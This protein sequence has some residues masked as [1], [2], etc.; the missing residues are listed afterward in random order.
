MADIT[1]LDGGPGGLG[2]H[3]LSSPARLD[4]CRLCMAPPE[5]SCFTQTTISNNFLIKKTVNCLEQLQNHDATIENFWTQK[6]EH[7]TR[8]GNSLNSMQ[9]R[10]ETPAPTTPFQH[11]YAGKAKYIEGIKGESCTLQLPKTT[12]VRLH[13]KVAP[14][15]LIKFCRSV[16]LVQMTFDS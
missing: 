3:G 13:R 16:E 6:Q 10:D 9:I 4:M 11:T 15:C 12:F 14:T 5:M 2:L 8:P 7:T 1:K